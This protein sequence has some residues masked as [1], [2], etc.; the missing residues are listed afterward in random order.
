MLGCF[1]SNASFEQVCA[2]TGPHEKVGV[3]CK[4]NGV[5]SV[6]RGPLLHYYVVLSCSTEL[7]GGILGDAS[8]HG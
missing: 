1:N 5:Y 8:H 6:V 2:K 3:L 7:V 4:R